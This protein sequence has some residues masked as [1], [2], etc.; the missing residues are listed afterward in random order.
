[1]IVVDSSALIAVLQHEPERDAIFQ[2]IADADRRLVSAVTY[3]EA[4]QVQFSRRGAQGIYDLEDF[5]KLIGAE[6]IP[7]DRELAEFAVEAFKRYGKGIHPDAR[8][9]FCDCA[10]Y[11]L[12]KSLDAPLLFKGDDFAATDIRAA[13]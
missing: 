10:V 6:I 2:A 9:N 12:A 8:L 11:A 3:Q 4:N 13:I 5:L 7:H 1:V